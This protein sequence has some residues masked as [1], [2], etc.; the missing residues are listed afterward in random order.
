MYNKSDV[1]LW[2]RVP[3]RQSY[4]DAFTRHKQLMSLYHD[5]S[6]LQRH[7][8]PKSDWEELKEHF[9]FLPSE[10]EQGQQDPSW[11]NRMVRIYHS[12]LFKEFCMCDLSRAKEIGKIALRWRTEEEVVEGLGQFTCANVNCHS[13]NELCPFEVN[14]GYVE[15]GEKKNAL[16]KIVLCSQCSPLLE[17]TRR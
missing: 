13:N 12:K 3:T 4:T 2:K 11:Q 5:P 14:F 7:S 17:H 16:V 1:P 6:Q 15:G 10:I 9:Q 8:L